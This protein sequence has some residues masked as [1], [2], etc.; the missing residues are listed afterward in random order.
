MVRFVG[1]F[2][3]EDANADPILAIARFIRYV[4]SLKSFLNN[5]CLGLL[6]QVYQRNRE[7]YQEHKDRPFGSNPLDYFEHP[8]RNRGEPIRPDH[9][10]VGAQFHRDLLAGKYPDLVDHQERQAADD[11]PAVVEEGLPLSGWRP[12]LRLPVQPSEPPPDHPPDPQGRSNPAHRLPSPPGYPPPNFS[13][14]EV[15]QYEPPPLPPPSEPPPDPPL[16]L[17]RDR[18]QTPQHPPGPPRSARLE[19]QAGSRVDQNTPRGRAATRGAAPGAPTSRPKVV[20]KERDSSDPRDN[21]KPSE[22]SLRPSSVSATS[23][24]ITPSRTV[25]LEAQQQPDQERPVRQVI[26]EEA[27]TG[28]GAAPGAPDPEEEQPSAPVREEFEEV[29]EEEEEPNERSR[30]EP[31]K[32]KLTSLRTSPTTR[33]LA[34]RPRVPGYP[35]IRVDSIGTWALIAPAERAP[36]T[37]LVGPK[38]SRFR[39]PHQNQGVNASSRQGSGHRR[40]AP[41]SFT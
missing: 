18:P 29:E 8:Q 37:R 23:R 34:L 41:N 12:S 20:L 30:S 13:P 9:Q 26:V 16:V 39:T 17:P 27:N 28:E 2:E 15:R 25:Q 33:P 38:S 24:T 19:Q 11:T 5:R 36:V 35:E 10:G 1:Q 22:V 6:Q 14:V 21:R 3:E 32:S 40:R 4:P 31:P 7:L